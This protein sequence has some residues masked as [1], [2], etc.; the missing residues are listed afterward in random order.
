MWRVSAGQIVLGRELTLA[1]LTV[2]FGDIAACPA[3]PRLCIALHVSHRSH[4]PQH[5]LI[6]SVILVASR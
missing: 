4:G 2:G 5:H 3:S 6:L 1:V